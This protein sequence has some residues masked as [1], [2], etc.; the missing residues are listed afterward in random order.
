MTD[1]LAWLRVMNSGGSDYYGSVATGKLW[2][3]DSSE[4]LNIEKPPIIPYLLT[5][6]LV[7][8]K[9]HATSSTF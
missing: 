5:M 8:I 3:R 1:V 6:W 4:Q 2:A 9:E 7:P